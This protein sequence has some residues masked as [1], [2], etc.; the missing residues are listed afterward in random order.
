MDYGIESASQRRPPSPELLALPPAQQ[1]GGKPLLEALR[2]R[3]SAREFSAQPLPVAVLSNLLWAAFGVNRPD[4]GGRTAPSAHDW[5]E[6]DLY[7]AMKTGL[8][9]YDAVHHGLRRKLDRDI[10]ADTGLQSFAAQAPLNL[11]FVADL[12]RMVHASAEETAQYAG[13]DA[14]FIAQNVYLFCASEGSRSA[15]LRR[16]EL[17]WVVPSAGTRPGTAPTARSPRS[18]AAARGCRSRARRRAAAGS[19]CARARPTRAA[20]RNR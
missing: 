5:E 20:R 1:R 7:A 11:V 16:L 9:L 19:R 14:G 12:S 4:T 17:P 8:Y 3:R 10:R 15:I 13:P 2:A 18:A 6:I